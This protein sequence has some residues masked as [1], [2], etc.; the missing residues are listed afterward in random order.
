VTRTRIVADLSGL[1]HTGF[2]HRVVTWWGELAFMALEGMGFVLSYGVFLYIALLNPQWPLGFPP[3][4]L[5]WSTL[6]TAIVALILIP[7]WLVMR[8]AKAHDN[9]GLRWLLVLMSLLGL[10]MLVVRYFEFAALTIRWDTNAYGSVLWALLG[11]HTL[12]I[13]TEVTDTIVMTAMYFTGHVPEKRFTDADEN[14]LYWLFVAIGW[15]PMYVLLYWA[16]R[17][18]AG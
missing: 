4:P 2:G 9:A 17:M 5:F 15:V 1:E 8:R 11:L 12:H 3:Q 16:P 7:N 13:A 6:F 14:A 18:G 10:S